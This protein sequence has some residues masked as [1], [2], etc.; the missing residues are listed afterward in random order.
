MKYRVGFDIGIKSV[1]YAVIEND[2]TT[3]EPMRI[4]DLGVRTFDANEVDKTG[5]STAKG[6][7]ELRGVRRRRRRKDFR[8]ERMNN[9]LNGTFSINY[10]EDVKAIQNV[11]VYKL[12]AN[13]LDMKIANIELCKVIFNILK[14]RGFK[15]SRKETCTNEKEKLKEQEKLKKAI[16]ENQEFIAKNGYRTIGEA[17]YKDTRFRMECNGRIVY[18][19]R[20]HN[21]C[22]NSFYRDDLK[23][24][25]N[26][27]LVSQQRFGNNLIT[28]EFI[29]KV[30]EIFSAQR[31]FDEGPGENSPY[32]ANFQVGKCTFIP[33][34]KRAPKASLTFE[35]FTALSK[36][37]SLKINY[38]NLNQEQFAILLEKVDKCSDIKFSQIRKWLN[39][40]YSKVFNLC[41]YYIKPKDAEGLTEREI[42]DKTEN[43]HFIKF[44]KTAEIRKA[45]MV[46]SPLEY[47]ELFD[48]IA[49]MLSLCKSDSTIDEYI[50]SHTIFN[51]LTAEQINN[52][53]TLNF[54][55]FGSLSVKA[56]KL[57][58]PYLEQGKKYNEACAMAG[59]NHSAKEFE[60]LKFLK[61][62]EIEER[63]QDITAPTVK[64]AV[65]QTI[66][67]L[68]EIIKKYGSPQFVTVELARDFGRTPNERKQ[69]QNAQQE[70]Y[71]S[72]QSYLDVIKKYKA[73]P[74]GVDF[75]KMRLY[76]EQNCKCMYSGETIELDKLFYDNYYQ[77]DHAIP[78]SR[79]LDDSYLNKVLVKTEEN[80]KKSD[81][82]PYDYFNKFKTQQEW[83]EYVARVNLLKNVKKKKLL[84]TTNFSENR[85]LEYIER[86]SNDTRAISKTVLNILQDYLYTAPNKK[87][88]K[89]IGCING[90]VTA[91]LRKCWGINKIREDGDAHHCIDA[92]VIAV[93]TDGEVQKITKFNK[94]KEKYIVRDDLIISKST[95]EVLEKDK[96]EQDKQAE[97]EKL[98]KILPKPYE[99][100]VKE[101]EI[102]STIKYD[103]S[104]Y[105]ER[106]KQELRNIGYIDEEIRRVKPLFVSRMKSVKT[107][108][109]IH[110]ETMYSSKIY[111]KT[112]LLIK[113]VPLKE[114]KIENKPESQPI[115][116]DKHPNV[117]IKGYYKPLDDRKLYLMLKESLI[118]DSKCFKDVNVVYK[119]SKNGVQ[120]MP[121][122]NVKVCV[123]KSNVA[124]INGGAF[125]N[126]KMYRVD[127]FTKDNKFYAIPVY[128]RDVYA[129][130]L[131]NKIVVS[132]GKPWVELDDSYTFKFSLYQ[133]DLVKVKW[134]KD[135]T[136]TKVNENEKSNKADKINLREGLFYYNTFSIS[137]ATIQIFTNDRCYAIDSAGIQGLQCFEKYYVDIMGKVYK[138]PSETRKEI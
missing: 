89:V 24:E 30:L 135:A 94:I 103:N 101:L 136:F 36:L 133:N 7:R 1:G 84:L 90:G 50:L 14:R 98:S 5:E 67:I 55:K 22:K 39:L 15:S 83:D 82:I 72:N 70:R 126:D 127:I 19:V 63:L 71:E 47:Q 10:Q 104:N 110:K 102:R 49:L 114:L 77:I 105:S 108:G 125:E 75:L 60:K 59:F 62:K 99:N 68:N 121:V 138:A 25:L 66:R 137:T 40:D 122:K 100:F 45:L 12:R 85:T 132:G 78:I 109:A 96:I 115:K 21:D 81:M 116:D 73:C 11:D 33:T 6:R 86:N 131:P 56:M 134:K 120:G 76:E 4:V 27:I 112:G 8:F 130:T 20:N 31:S 69:V 41:N 74:S 91:Y 58:I 57:I 3:E 34:E 119:P 97:I 65:N 2:N 95:G 129:H 87:Y 28:N 46:S 113:T 93:A 18:N 111:D 54:D 52:I 38:E 43:K 80:Q 37:N 13:A 106:E 23:N 124:L 64:R 26:L 92:V 51:N 48:E 53:K 35:R 42:I 128:M 79:S 107:T 9:L 29:D 17:I 44:D 118:K 32:K 16:A 117:S 123:Y 88:K 61:G